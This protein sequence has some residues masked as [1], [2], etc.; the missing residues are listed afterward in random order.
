MSDQRPDPITREDITGLREDTQGL[1]HS[2]DRFATKAD[3][4]LESIKRRRLSLVVVLV[5]VALLAAGWASWTAHES[6][7]DILATRQSARLGVCTAMNDM[8]LKHNHF[9]NTTI[10]ER[11]AI[12]DGIRNGDGTDDQK[13]RSAQF[14]QAQIDSYRSDLLPTINCNDPAALASLFTNP[15]A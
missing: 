1:T 4:E 5:V 11:Q 9:V 8:R 13:A 3:V 10:T 15:G 7:D 6:V 14:F 2:I 12:I